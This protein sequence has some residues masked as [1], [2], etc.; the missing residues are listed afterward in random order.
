MGED[1]LISPPWDTHTL[2]CNT[3]CQS[4][5]E[6][7]RR[8][9]RERGFFFFFFFSIWALKPEQLEVSSDEH[10]ML[11]VLKNWHIQQQFLCVCLL[12]SDSVRNVNECIPNR[13]IAY[14]KGGEERA[15]ESMDD[16][17][18]RKGRLQGVEMSLF[19]CEGHVRIKANS[20]ETPPHL[21]LPLPFLPSLSCRC[22]SKIISK[23]KRCCLMVPYFP[24]WNDC[25]NV[26]NTKM[27]HNLPH[28]DCSFVKLTTK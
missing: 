25:P 19:T 23:N 9:Q 12:L 22:P 6:N 5:R 27:F 26:T 11:R 8:R 4:E 13:W 10:W 28:G 18:Y 2:V 21:H 24:T 7:K 14:W 16:I 15:K 3:Y 20:C 1:F 17:S